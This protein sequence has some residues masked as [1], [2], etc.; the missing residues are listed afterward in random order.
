MENL[1]VLSDL[2]I[3]LRCV[4]KAHDG[5][6]KRVGEAFGL[7]ALEVQIL[8]FLHLQPERNLAGEIA[9]ARMFSKGNVS[10]AV[11]NLIERGFLRRTPD[12]KDR[13]RIR[14]FLLPPA[15]PVAD[16]IDREIE[17]FVTRL[18]EGCSEEELA[19]HA[20]VR[21][22]LADNARALLES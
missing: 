20:A 7:A 16:R 2:V 4:L 6:M 17:K 3:C 9:Q 21:K 13:R 10:Q 14:L 8:A 22:K 15:G 11:E 5:A 18:F 19:R 12:E 1:E